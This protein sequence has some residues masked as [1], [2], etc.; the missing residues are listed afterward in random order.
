[1]ITNN[2]GVYKITNIITGGYYIGSSCN[3]RNRIY[4]HR[5]QLVNNTHGNRHLQRAW[6]KYGVD[7]FEFTV[8]LL[9]EIE[10]VIEREQFYIDNE[11]PYYNIC[12]IAGS[13]RGIKLSD[14]CKRKLSEVNTGKHHTS[15]T[16]LKLSKFNKGKHLSEEHKR[17]IS[18]SNTGKHVLSDEA[19]AK[20]SAAHKGKP[21]SDA[22]RKAD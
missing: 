10:Y 18:E 14:E 11:K 12:Q 9:C 7:N 20:M 8:V 5:W 17:K 3:I 4:H 2:C 6:N 21:W 16:K 22:R 1:M 15:K 13:C 19:H